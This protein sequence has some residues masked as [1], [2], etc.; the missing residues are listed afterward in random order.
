MFIN[1]RE[2]VLSAQEKGSRLRALERGEREAETHRQVVISEQ[3]GDAPP[4]T[5]ASWVDGVKTTG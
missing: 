3:H 2:A 5:L 1:G 4:W